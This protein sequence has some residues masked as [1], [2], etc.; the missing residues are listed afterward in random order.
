[1]DWRRPSGGWGRDVVWA[2]LVR[3]TWGRGVGTKKAPA[4]VLIAASHP[5]L[6]MHIP[7]YQ[8]LREQPTT[9]TPI[10]TTRAHPFATAR[11]TSRAYH[12]IVLDLHM[13]ELKVASPAVAKPHKLRTDEKEDGDLD[14][15]RCQAPS[16]G[17]YKP[18]PFSLVYVSVIV[19]NSFWSLIYVR[20]ARFRSSVYNELFKKATINYI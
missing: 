1:L 6:R 11:P 19:M 3:A 10:H 18:F 14:T 5:R 20:L 17:C 13:R 4:P 12:P 7:I 2:A 9:K 8:S 15:A 16:H